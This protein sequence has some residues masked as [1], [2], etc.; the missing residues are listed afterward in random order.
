MRNGEFR[1]QLLDA[2]SALSAFPALRVVLAYDKIRK[3]AASTLLFRIWFA[4]AL[5]RLANTRATTRMQMAALDA[6]ASRNSTSDC[7]VV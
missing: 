6:A 2:L 7:F 5:L 3:T 4:R 1:V